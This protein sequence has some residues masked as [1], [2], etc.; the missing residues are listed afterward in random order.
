M[1]NTDLHK[2]LVELLQDASDYFDHTSNSSQD[3]QIITKLT[4]R[5][6]QVIGEITVVVRSFPLI[7]D[8]DQDELYRNWKRMTAALRLCAYDYSEG[9]DVWDEDIYR[10]YRPA[11]QSEDRR[12][13]IAEAREEFEKAHAAV[14]R[15]LSLVSSLDE[16]SPSFP[17][18]SQSL[19][20]F[21]KDYPESIKTAFVMMRFGT[22]RVHEEIVSAIKQTLELNHIIGLRADDKQYHSDLFPNVLTYIYGCSIGIAVFERIENEEFNPNVALEVGYM[23]A[24]RKPVCFLKDRT[25]K[26]LHTDLIGKLYKEFDQLD[27]GS[28][29]PKE[30]SKWL[31]DQE[32][33]RG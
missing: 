5:I 29:I 33:I 28:T 8:A 16:L 24:L 31:E 30:L 6:D 3:S 19:K 21:R 25:L 22:T 26:T 12:I 13:S 15:V 14:L 11:S 2:L 4:Y 9:Y 7:K 10:G 27:P 17:E 23:L 18:I 20:R 32:I 1:N